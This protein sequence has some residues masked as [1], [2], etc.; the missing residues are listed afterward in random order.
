[1]LIHPSTRVEYI[2]C[3][4][5]PEPPSPDEYAEPRDAHEGALP[6]SAADF[7]TGPDNNDLPF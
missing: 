4:D 6:Y 7:I 5:A 3:D 1:M 2:D